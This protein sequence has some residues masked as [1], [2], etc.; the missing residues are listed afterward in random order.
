MKDPITVTLTLRELTLIRVACLQRLD[1]LKNKP[2]MEASYAESRAMLDV[3]GVLYKAARDA[4][5][6]APHTAA[7]ELLAAADRH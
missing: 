2:H 1:R 5:V 6:I 3:D 4:G 7:A